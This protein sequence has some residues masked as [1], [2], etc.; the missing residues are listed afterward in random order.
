[1]VKA[2]IIG[3]DLSIP[4]LESAR[5]KSL[6]LLRVD[7]D[8]PKLPFHDSL[9][10]VIIGAYIV[11]QVK[12][13]DH[14]FLECHRVLRDGIL[15]LLT[16]SH[17]QIERQHPVI[18]QF[19]PSFINIDKARFPDIPRIDYLLNSAGFTDIEHHEVI[20]ENLVIDEE[21]LQK[22]KAKYVSTYCLLPQSE[23]E[24][25]VKGLEKFI[26]SKNKPEVREWQGTFIRGRK[27]VG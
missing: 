18:K 2:D 23:F 22:V 6:E 14:L 4:M 15:L 16:S 21:Y 5:G 12:N 25:G 8:N 19:F 10:D 11:H 3:L 24:A 26:K 9:F 20:M 7:V 17:A 1:V 13:L 27:H